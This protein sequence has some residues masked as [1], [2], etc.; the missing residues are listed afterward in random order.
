MSAAKTQ[1]GISLLAF[2]ALGAGLMLKKRKSNQWDLKNQ[3][4]FNSLNIKPSQTV[5]IEV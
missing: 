4:S 5:E 1:S 3:F 2:G